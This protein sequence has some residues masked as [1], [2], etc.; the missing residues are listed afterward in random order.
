MISKGKPAT[1]TVWLR[2]EG[3]SAWYPVTGAQVVTNELGAVLTLVSANGDRY[4]LV[5]ERTDAHEQSN[6][7]V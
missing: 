4:T 7:N 5:L 3:D 2:T 6:N 1:E